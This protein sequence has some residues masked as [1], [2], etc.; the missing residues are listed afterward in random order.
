MQF[1]A[2]GVQLRPGQF[3]AF[4]GLSPDRAKRYDA[5]QAVFKSHE[6]NVLPAIE[7]A[8]DKETDARI[9]RALSEARAAIILNADD[10]GEAVA[11]FRYRPSLRGDP[12]RGSERTHWQSTS[13]RR[14]GLWT[15]QSAQGQGARQYQF[16]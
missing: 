12:A 3:A 1:L 16:R 6:A 11:D 4:H 14:A 15:G 5:A 9:K 8:I 7:A 10:A 13:A 2:P